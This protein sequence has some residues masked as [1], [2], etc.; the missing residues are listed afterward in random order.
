[1]RDREISSA[2]DKSPVPSIS[3]RSSR[4]LFSPRFSSLR[5]VL[6]TFLDRG[7]NGASLRI[8][9]NRT[10][11][12]L[13]FQKYIVSK[14]VYGFNLLI[15]YTNESKKY[16]PEIGDYCVQHKILFNV[17]ELTDNETSKCIRIDCG[18]DVDKAHVLLN[19]I[20]KDVIGLPPNSKFS[21]DWEKISP[22]REVID[23]PEQEPAPASE[24]L[25]LTED[26][27]RRRSGPGPWPSGPF[28]VALFFQIFGVLGLILTLL[29]QEDDWSGVTIAVFDALLEVPWSGLISVL[30]VL[31]GF[32]AIFSDMYWAIPK[33]RGEKGFDT[34]PSSLRGALL[35]FWGRPINW[36]SI[37]LIFAGVYSWLT[38]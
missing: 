33:K 27:F 3:F 35:V 38:V 24:G 22:W 29:L 37:L 25:K 17:D 14:G 5:S 4:W 7:L 6:E 11:F 23:S 12:K 21:I 18:K 32:L 2:V 1:M 10:R 26:W 16:F 31:F 28:V 8:Q 9:E 20:L 15:N 36:V 13:Q 19:D 34:V 30:F